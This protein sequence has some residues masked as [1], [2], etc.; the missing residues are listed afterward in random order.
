MSDYAWSHS[1]YSYQA[2][3]VSQCTYAG[4]KEDYAMKSAAAIDAKFRDFYLAFAVVYEV[5]AGGW[6]GYFEAGS[7]SDLEA[8]IQSLEDLDL[9]DTKQLLE[10]AISC[11]EGG[12]EKSRKVNTR[13]KCYSI[14]RLPDALEDLARRFYESPESGGDAPLEWLLSQVMTK[15]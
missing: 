10:E 1:K 4:L 9:L 13:K 3:I 12:I 7:S 6:E 8:T 2:G 5:N 11:F 14:K 15:E